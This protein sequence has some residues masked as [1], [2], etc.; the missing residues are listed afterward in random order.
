MSTTSGLDRVSGGG[1]G[2]LRAS[3]EGPRTGGPAAGSVRRG[4]PRWASGDR[5]G[6][7]AVRR[8]PGD[9]VGSSAVRRAPGDRVGSSAVRWASGGSE[10]GAAGRP[11]AER[12]AG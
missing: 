5:V 4:A 11:G 6:S 2:S 12:G 9:R 3:P 10:S 7:S 1:T 8:A